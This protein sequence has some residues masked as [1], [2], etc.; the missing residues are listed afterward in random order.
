MTIKEAIWFLSAPETSALRRRGDPLGLRN[1]TDEVAELL[2]PGLTNRTRDARWLTLLSWSLVESDLAWHKAGSGNLNT[3]EHRR[4]RYRWLRPLELLWVARS[5][6]LGGKGYR[7]SH[8]PGYRSLKRWDKNSARF[9]MTATQLTNYRQ[10]GAYGAYR[11]LFRQNGLTGSNDGW[12]PAN[13]TYGLAEFVARELKREGAAPT[14]RNKPRL[15][16]P[17]QW[18]IV[19][20]WPQWQTAGQPNSLMLSGLT[21]TRLH[22]DEINVL[23]PLLFP[24]DS[25]RLRTAQA[26]G[27]NCNSRDYV[28]LCR[29]LAKALP[30]SGG[31]PSLSRLGDL[32][33]LNGAGI[34]LLRSIAQ[35][36][37][38]GSRSIAALPRD[39]HVID[40]LEAFSDCAAVW[41]KTAHD[42]PPFTHQ[43]EADRLAQIPTRGKLASLTRFIAHHEQR[44]SGARWFGLVGDEIIL[45]GA[46]S[47][48]ESGSF[49]Y[50]L[51]AVARLAVQCGVL[52]VLPRAL[53]G[54]MLN[55]DDT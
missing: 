11:T 12:T 45:I 46:E 19:T 27:K 14:W 39:P 55:E 26:I 44:G 32:A 16:D 31:D 48:V 43:D 36:A 51:H 25:P 4:E 28:A 10:S 30:R 24:S 20:G 21:P 1:V 23:A 8:W 33:A 54:Y 7:A 50:R 38:T 47:G 18:W 15:N 29:S 9:A 6:Q 40:A 52:A 2:A 42:A 35:C 5:I 41:R 53:G 3:S 22:Q 17:A 13:S 34:T 37:T 49:G